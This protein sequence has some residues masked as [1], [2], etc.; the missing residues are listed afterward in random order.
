MSNRIAPFFLGC[1]DR[2]FSL[3]DEAPS[4]PHTNFLIPYIVDF[5]LARR[6][7]G[8][9]RFNPYTIYGYPRPLPELAHQHDF[10][11]APMV[12]PSPLGAGKWSK[13]ARIYL[14]FLSVIS[15]FLSSLLFF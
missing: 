8:L 15:I 11:E 4:F 5:I 12:S 7:K 10:A 13:Y 9:W 14:A 3:D 1:Q 2:N 6:H